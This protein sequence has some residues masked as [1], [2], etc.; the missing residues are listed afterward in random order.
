MEEVGG[1]PGISSG[2]VRRVDPGSPWDSSPSWTRPVR[3]ERGAQSSCLLRGSPPPPPR[4]PSRAPSVAASVRDPDTGPLPAASITSSCFC[5]AL[6]GSAGPSPRPLLGFGS[7]L[8]SL[9]SPPLPRSSAV[10]AAGH[11]GFAA[12]RL[13]S[14]TLGG[15]TSGEEAGGRSGNWESTDGALP[16]GVPRLQAGGRAGV[17]AASDPE[18]E[19]EAEG[20]RTL[21][22]T[23]GAR[24]PGL[25]REVR[26]VRALGRFPCKYWGRSRRS[27]TSLGTLTQR[28]PPGSRHPRWQ[29]WLGKE[30]VAGGPKGS[31]GS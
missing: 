15:G 18:G 31:D 20:R 5:L 22:V 3:S 28:S 30:T 25:P 7:S 2:P 21:G 12:T 23:C 10:A 17:D 4:W 29:V 13:G 24:D 26:G 1:G 19:P 27:T 14:Q 9:P 6:R 8:P 16:R 11:G